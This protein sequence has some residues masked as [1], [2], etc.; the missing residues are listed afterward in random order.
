MDEKIKATFM[1]LQIVR[2]PDNL[3]VLIENEQFLGAITR[4]FRHA[5]TYPSI[6]QSISPILFQHPQPALPVSNTPSRAPS[7][8]TPTYTSKPYPLATRRQAWA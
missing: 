2:D 4:I 8:N 3:E 7:L 6:K 1:I 5:H